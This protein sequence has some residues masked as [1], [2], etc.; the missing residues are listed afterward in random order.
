[1][2]ERRP[3]TRLAAQ[4]QPASPVPLPLPEV[5]HDMDGGPHLKCDRT[6][7]GAATPTNGHAGTEGS[8]AGGPIKVQRKGASVALRCALAVRGF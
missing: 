6:E 4:T 7:L 8:G 3:W 5:V 2:T 1:M